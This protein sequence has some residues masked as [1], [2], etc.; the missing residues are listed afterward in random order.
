MAT[1]LF[2]THQ[3]YFFSLSGIYY[4]LLCQVYISLYFPHVVGNCKSNILHQLVFLS[5]FYPRA[6][7][8]SGRTNTHGSPSESFAL[9]SWVCLLIPVRTSHCCNYY[10]VMVTTSC[11]HPSSECLF[12]SSLFLAH[13]DFTIKLMSSFIDNPMGF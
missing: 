4:G 10:N 5:V 9:F 8:D 2:C 11:G 6:L 12:Y 7:V 1:V 3:T 13:M